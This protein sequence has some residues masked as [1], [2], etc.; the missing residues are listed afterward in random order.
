MNLPEDNINNRDY[1]SEIELKNI[2]FFNQR[3]IANFKIYS[4]IAIASIKSR[5]EYRTSFS[6]FLFTLIMFYSSQA[7]TISAIVYRFKTIGGWTLGEMAFLYSVLIL[8]MGL[9]SS[10]FSGLIDFYE[11]I[12]EGTFD[13][14]LLRPLSPLGQIIAGGFEI[15]GVVHLILGVTA[16]W[17][18][19]QLQKVDWNWLNII[20]FITVILGG[21][22]I[23]ASIRIII[24]SIAFYAVNNSSLVHLFVFSTREFMLYPMS[25]YPTGLKFILTFLLPLGF[26][27]YYP[28]YYFLNKS[29]EGDLFH[30]Y[31]MFGSLPVGIL[32]AITSL[33]LW[34]KGKKAYESAGS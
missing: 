2:S 23:L 18:A 5:M 33:I 6:V 8:S 3:L 15:T 7:L 9:V 27:N 17:I 31:L 26:I 22:L 20:V 25:I 30:P 16:F 11:F 29:T 19:N 13:R 10:M 32:M 4:K 34:E 24:A 1:A 14:I 21:S 12:R 28:A